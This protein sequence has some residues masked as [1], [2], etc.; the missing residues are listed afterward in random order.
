MLDPQQFANRANQAS[1]MFD[2]SAPKQTEDK[3]LSKEEVRS[4]LSNVSDK[5]AALQKLVSD[6]YEIE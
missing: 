5:K 1:S 3:K 4:L 2:F 6:G